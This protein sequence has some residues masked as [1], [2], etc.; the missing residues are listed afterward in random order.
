MCE[1]KIPPEQI[2]EGVK[3]AIQENEILHLSHIIG[4]V[5]YS[6]TEIKE[7]GV[8]EN[9]DVINLIEKNQARHR[10]LILEG[11]LNG[12]AKEKL[13]AYTIIASKDEYLRLIGTNDN[14][15]SEDSNQ[16]PFLEDLTSYENNNGV[17]KNTGT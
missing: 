15:T 6:L 16:K 10:H 7:A 17:E 9:Q 3:L 13:Q 5:K 14:I 4:F 1:K 11:L 8:F 12:T 2:I